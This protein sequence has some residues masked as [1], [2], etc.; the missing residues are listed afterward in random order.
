MKARDVA[1]VTRLIRND[2]R[3]WE[4]LGHVRSMD[5]PDCWIGAGF[6][7]N[8]VWSE[9]HHAAPEPDHDVDVIWFDRTRSESEIDRSHEVALKAQEPSVKWSVKNQARMH[10]S[11]GD[12]PYLSSADA[13]RHWPE[14][15]TAVAVRR[16]AS[17]EC[18]LLAPFGLDDL[19][20]MKLRPAGEFAGSKRVIFEQRVRSKRWLLDF[21]KLELVA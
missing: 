17:D 10:L 2:S 9:L 8:P 3:R 16:T 21:P 13:M 7:R 12:A 11:N 4:L 19:L 18:E 1:F 14:T 20:G 15:A 6:V 5:L